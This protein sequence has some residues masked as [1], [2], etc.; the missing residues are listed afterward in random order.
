MKLAL[1][2]NTLKLANFG[3]K[4]IKKGYTLIDTPT[5]ESLQRQRRA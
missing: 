3:K 1:V 4:L 5:F 2:A